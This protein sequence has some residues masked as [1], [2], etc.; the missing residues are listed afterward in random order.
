ML[1][2]QDL[3]VKAPQP[4]ISPAQLRDDL[5]MSKRANRTVLGG[6]RDAGRGAHPAPAGQAAARHRRSLLHS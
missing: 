3:H 5:A 4:V 2:T 1:E 6:R